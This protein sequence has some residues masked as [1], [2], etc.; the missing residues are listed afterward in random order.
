MMPENGSPTKDEREETLGLELARNLFLTR[1]AHEASGLDIVRRQAAMAESLAKKTQELTIGKSDAGGEDMGVS[2]GNSTTNN[3]GPPP[4]TPE[5]AT[6][7]PTWA[8]YL[9]AALAAGGL[10]GVAG[11][12]TLPADD[13]PPPVV[14]EPAGDR[15]MEYTIEKWTP[16]K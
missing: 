15:W 10:G 7:L 6:G 8:K 3:Y 4:S 14:A 5:K 9:A 2:V 16:D 11:Y 1:I 12:N 13:Q